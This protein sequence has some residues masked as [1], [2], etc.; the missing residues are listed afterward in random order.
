VSLRIMGVDPSLSATGMCLPDNRVL[1]IKCKSEWGDDRLLLIRNVVRRFVIETRPQ[2]VVMEDKLHSS[3][4]AAPL[5]MVQ[6][7]VRAELLDHGVQYV[8]ISPKTLK[9]F[10]TGNGNA[11][12]DDM[13]AAARRRA[14]MIFKDDNQCDAWFLRQAGLDHYG[15]PT[16]IRPDRDLSLALGVVTWPVCV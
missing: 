14:G 6:G 7:V 13:I 15:L 4:S 3:F 1:T 10:A 12:K 16:D 8:L 11:D 9:K 5:G 2:L